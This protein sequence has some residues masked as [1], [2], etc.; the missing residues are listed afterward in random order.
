[1]N[2][3]YKQKIIDSGN[4]WIFDEDFS[5]KV[6]CVSEDLDAILSAIV[7]CNCKKG[8]EIG[9]FYDFQTG[10]YRKQG[11]D[12][13]KEMICIDLSHPI[14]KSISNH[15]TDIGDGVINVNDINLSNLDGVNVDNYFSKYNLSTYLLV[16]SLM[17]LPIPKDNKKLIMLLPDS[18]FLGYYQPSCYKDG[19]VQKK[20]LVDVLELEEL[21]ELQTRTEKH[22]FYNAQEELATKSKMIVTANG[23][24]PVDSN[25]NIE[26]ICNLIDLD[27]NPEILS[28]FFNC[29]EVH[30]SYSSHV[31][32]INKSDLYSFA[33]T[34]KSQ[35][36][37]SKRVDDLEDM[38]TE[39]Y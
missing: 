11:I 7:L 10:L 13:N 22:R 39:K 4:G 28:G 6:L 37:Y 27:Y 24:E 15:V 36:K 32:K 31:K 19:K 17:E 23:I 14:K 5:N 25:C 1:M 21:Y 2:K 30:R 34:R 12:E 29:I 33:I 20:Y 38:L 8:L 16:H 35:M 9:Y 26:R 18:S 3:E